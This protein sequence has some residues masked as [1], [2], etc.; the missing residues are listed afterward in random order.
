MK[1]VKNITTFSIA[2]LLGISM[3]INFNDCSKDST[4]QPVA[5]EETTLLNLSLSKEA[6]L[7]AIIIENLI[8]PETGGHL[9]INKKSVNNAD[10]DIRAGNVSYATLMQLVKLSETSNSYHLI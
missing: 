2:L 10:F 9:K 1:R 3:T 4:M 6:T 8:Y 5:S 7:K